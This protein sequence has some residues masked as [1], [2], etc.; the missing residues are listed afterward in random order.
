MQTATEMVKK[1]KIALFLQNETG[2]YKRIKKSTELTISMNPEEN[3]YDYISDENPTK[4][5]D[6]YVPSI[7]QDLTMFK[8]EEDYEMVFPYFYERRTGSEAHTGCM[9]V[10]KQEPVDA[11]GKSIAVG[12]TTTAVAGYKAWLTDSVISVQ[13]LTAVDKKLNFKVYFAG[14]VTEG[15]AS[16]VDGVPTFTPTNAAVSS[17]GT[18]TTTTE[19]E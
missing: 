14:D 5:V 4:E 6:R 7:D 1:H 10:F 8:G 18:T 17:S 11:T 19:G 16:I 2:V 9:V 12:D 3:D 13:D 15:T